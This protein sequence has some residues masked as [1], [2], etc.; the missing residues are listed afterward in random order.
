MTMARVTFWQRRIAN[1]GERPAL[2]WVV[3]GVVLVEFVAW[4]VMPWMVF[5]VAGPLLLWVVAN[6]V[7]GGTVVSLELDR[8]KWREV[9]FPLRWPKS[10]KLDGGECWLVGEVRKRRKHQVG[11]VVSYGAGL[12]RK[13]GKV[14]VIHEGFRLRAE[15]EEVAREL[16]QRTGLRVEAHS[17]LR[18]GGVGERGE[19][20]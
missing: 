6:V 10:G 17:P 5:A 18:R 12:R 19:A 9:A 1:L 4:F 11:S 15:A 8:G 7:W 3:V 16:A 14:M 20:G 13:N 2:H